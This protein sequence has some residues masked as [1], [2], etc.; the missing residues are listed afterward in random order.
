MDAIEHEVLQLQARGVRYRDIRAILGISL[1]RLRMI[2]RV[3]GLP[4]L[5][6]YSKK[7]RGS[8]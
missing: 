1:A 3:H 4:L 8:K 2:L 5:C 6:P 7:E